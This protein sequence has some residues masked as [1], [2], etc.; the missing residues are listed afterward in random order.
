MSLIICA[1]LLALQ[2]EVPIQVPDGWEARREQGVL[3]AMPKQLDPGTVYTVLVP[4]LA[5]KLGSL[6][7]LLDACKETLGEVG[8]FEPATDPVRGKTDGQWEF[9]FVIGTLEQDGK[10]LMAQATGLIKGG[11]E[12]ILLVISDSL[13]TMLKH[14]D[15]LNLMLRS[16]GAP[17]AAP[18]AAGGGT[19][20]AT[21]HLK[22]RLP[23]GWQSSPG[24]NDLLLEKTENKGVPGEM[25][26]K[27]ILLPSRPLQDNLRKTF[28]A[29][30]AEQITPIMT[31][32]FAPLPMMRRLKS[33]LAVAYEVD[34]GAKNVKGVT[35]IGGLYLLS[36]GKLVVPMIA[37]HSGISPGLEA[38]LLE[39]LESGSIADAGDEKTPLFDAADLAGEWHKSS[40]SLANFVTAG[41]AYAGDASMSIDI[42]FTLNAGGAYK[43]QF[44][45]VGRTAMHLKREGTWTVDDMSLAVTEKDKAPY[46]YRLFGVGG[47]AKSGRYLVMSFA[48]DT[49]QQLDLSNPRGSGASW[50]KRKE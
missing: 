24:T 4:P 10:K 36:Q 48:A 9:E 8:K 15:R 6:K 11:D 41:G 20:A 30:W 37:V 49:A 46:R 39:L 17:K 21:K 18:P 50:F 28:H 31:P 32:S 25:T 44:T 43:Y 16:V 33:G 5:K 34:P 42:I 35:I 1:A 19:A 22:F 29:V 27:L 14:A 23:A 3:L 45:S 2:T 26:F 47:D 13:E 7:L 40:V 12:G 38:D